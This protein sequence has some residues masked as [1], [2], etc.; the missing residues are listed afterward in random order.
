MSQTQ[1]SQTSS[2]TPSATA[3]VSKDSLGLGHTSGQRGA[4]ILAGFRAE[5]YPSPD[6]LALSRLSGRIIARLLMRMASSDAPANFTAARFAIIEALTHRALP[7]DE[8]HPIIVEIAAGMSPRGLRLARHLPRAQVIEVDLPDVIR[9]KQE[10]LKRAKKVEIPPNIMW[11]SADLGTTPLS[12]VL[13]GK[14]AD[15]VAAE[16]LLPYFFPKEITE[17]TRGVLEC[18]KPGGKFIADTP[19]RAGMEQLKQIM[20]FFSQQAGKLKGVVS[21]EAEAQQ[22]LLDAGYQSVNVYLA[23]QLAEEF[24]LHTPLVDAS[25]FIEAQKAKA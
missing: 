2:V 13:D 15:V 10:R 1:T 9:E 5:K 3:Q 21:S 12:V 7:P 23:T 25:F 14:L 17:I 18:L 6:T 24:K 19:S 22:M 11:L 8:E 20:G 4:E 16:G